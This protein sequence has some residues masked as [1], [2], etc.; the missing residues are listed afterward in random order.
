MIFIATRWVRPFREM[1]RCPMELFLVQHAESKPK[2]EDSERSLTEAGVAAARR[3]ADWAARVGVRIDHIRHSGKTRA[4]QTA[5]I[6]GERLTPKTGVQAVPGINPLDD[7]APL[8]EELQ[9]Q[10]EPLMLVGHLP[11]L[12]RLAGSLLA[13]DPDRQVVKFENTGLVCLQRTEGVW[14]L[15][16]VMLPRLLNIA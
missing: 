14:S 7:P 9:S 3:M 11:F 2:E 13:G 10:A 15:S 5:S 12:S 16:W 1:E 8:A 6:L 4:A